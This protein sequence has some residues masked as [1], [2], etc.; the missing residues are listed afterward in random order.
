MAAAARRVVCESLLQLLPRD[1]SVS[2][3]LQFILNSHWPTTPK[4]LLGS[5][6][7]FALEFQLLHLNGIVFKLPAYL[8]SWVTASLPQEVVT[9]GDTRHQLQLV[10]LSFLCVK[11]QERHSGLGY[12]N[13]V[14]VKNLE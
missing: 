1:N 5:F 7:N 2:D 11:A 10:M 4:S 6:N 12:F 3:F 13:R 8:L 14:A 9:R